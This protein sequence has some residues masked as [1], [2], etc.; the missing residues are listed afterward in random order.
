MSF[1]TLG[2][3]QAVLADW[4]SASLMSW[5]VGSTRRIAEL[6]VCVAGK[7]DGKDW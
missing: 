4:Q 7:R 3:S 1:S 6:G 2:F 5:R